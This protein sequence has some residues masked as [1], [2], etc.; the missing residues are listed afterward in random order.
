MC[1]AVTPHS[2]RIGM[3]HDAFPGHPAGD[4]R[5][6]I[7]PLESSRRGTHDSS[8]QYEDSPSSSIQQDRE[9]YPYSNQPAIPGDDAGLT[10][11][12][13]IIGHSYSS[14]IPPPDIIVGYEK[15]ERGLGKRILDD[16]H[17]DTTADRQNTQ[18]AFDYRIWEAK[19]GFIVATVITVLGIVGTFL[20]LLFL[21]PPES[22]AGATFL[23]IATLTPLANTFLNR[24]QQGQ[25]QSAASLP[26]EDE[27]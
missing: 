6:H 14:P 11:H 27:S 8:P 16:A 2:E 9:Q 20:S 12:G 24:G 21:D 25:H 18:K 26:K 17:Q 4:E 5:D 23:G 7:Q 19:A 10:R 3:E 1:T 22:I 13:V 15:I